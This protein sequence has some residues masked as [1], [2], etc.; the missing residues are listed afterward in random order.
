MPTPR[1]KPLHRRALTVERLE[2]RRLL[3]ADF[4]DAPIST[5]VSHEAIGPRL[6]GL[7]DVDAS[8]MSTVGAVGDGSDDDGVFYGVLR[9]GQTGAVITVNVQNAPTGA[10][11]DAWW[12]FNGNNAWTADE[13]I[14]DNLPVVEG[15]NA[16]TFDIPATA[17][18]GL[19]YARFRLSTAGDLNVSGV[20]LDGEVEDYYIPIARGDDELFSGLN[21]ISL[22]T[23]YRVIQADLDG[24]GDDDLITGGGSRVDWHENL[25]GAFATPRQIGVTSGN[26]SFLK[27]GDIDGDGD[28]DVFAATSSYNL[29]WFEND[30][31][32]TFT[33]QAISPTGGVVDLGDLDGDGDWDLITSVGSAAVYLN[34]GVTFAFSSSLATDMSAVASIVATDLDGDADVDVLAADTDDGAIVWF[35]NNGSG[36]LTRHTVTTLADL[37]RSAMPA[38]VDGDGDFDVVASVDADLVWY[39]NDG[40]GEFTRRL[41][42]EFAGAGLA[43]LGASDIDGDGDVDLLGATLNHKL[44]LDNDGSESFVT[45]RLYSAA[46]SGNVIVVDVDGD[47]RL[48]IVSARGSS[49]PLLSWQRQ[50]AAMDFGDAPM[51]YRTH[52]QHNGARHNAVGPRLGALRDAE[53]DGVHDDSEA[54]DDGVTFGTLQVGGVGTVTVNVQDAPDGARLDAWIDFDGDGSWGLEGERIAANLAVVEGDNEL[55]FAVPSWAAAGVT[56]ARFRLS[57]EGGHGVGGAA[58]DGEVEDYQV[59]LTAPAPATGMFG[60]PTTI[61]AASGLGFI[62]TADVDRDGDIDV[63]TRG[64]AW[65]EN[66]GSEGFVSHGVPGGA[67]FGEDIAA[68]D[69]DSDGDVDFVGLGNGELVWMENDGAQNFTLRRTPLLA[70][71]NSLVSLAIADMDGDGD[72]DVVATHLFS[73]PAIYLLVNDGS[74]QFATR[75]IGMLSRYAT[76]VVAADMDRDGDLDVVAGGQGLSSADVVWLQNDGALGF[77]Q[78]TV[79]PMA[80]FG[81]ANA[82]TEGVAVGDLDGD[83]DLDVVAAG[84]AVSVGSQVRASLS[85]HEQVDGGAFVQHDLEFTRNLRWATLA[86]IDGDGDLDILTSG[87][88]NAIDLYENL[89][90]STFVRRLVSTSLDTGWSVAAA[91]MDGDGD[92][93]VVGVNVATGVG[94]AWF[95]NLGYDEPDYGDAPASYGTLRANGGAEHNSAGPRLGDLRD[96]ETDGVPNTAADG[97]G[98]DDD[99]VTFG[100]LRAGEAGATITINVQNAAAGARVDAWIDFNGDGLWAGADEHVVDSASVVDGDNSFTFSVSPSAA[101]GTTYARVRVSTAGHQGP[102]GFAADGEVEDYAVTV[103]SPGETTGEYAAFRS[104]FDSITWVIRTADIDGDGD[105]DIVSDSTTGGIVWHENLN[106]GAFLRHPLPGAFSGSTDLQVVD[107]DRDGDA[108]FVTIAG[109]NVSW[110]E[111]NGDQSFRRRTIFTVAGTIGSSV[112]V[113]DAD[114]DGDWDVLVGLPGGIRWFINNGQ[115]SFASVAIAPSTTSRR[116]RAVDLDGDGDLD[117]V[118]ATPN[119][120][121]LENRGGNYTSHAQAL[122]FVDDFVVADVDR[123]GDLDVVT[124]GS[125]VAWHEN[126][127]GATFVP[128]MIPVSVTSLSTTVQG[129]LSVVDA[130]GD[131]DLDILLPGIGQPRWFRNDGAQNFSLVTVG[132]SLGPPEAPATNSIS[133]VAAD[134]NGDGRLEVLIGSTNPAQSGW[135]EPL[136]PGDYDRNGRVDE[137]DRELWEQTLGQPAT[138]PGS[139][140]DGDA[141]GQV[142]E[143]D[144]AVWEQHAGQ[145]LIPRVQ[146][147]HADSGLNEMIDGNDFLVWQ[148]RVGLLGLVAA[149]YDWDLSGGVDGG[150]LD[151]WRRQYGQGVAPDIAWIFSSPGSAAAAAALNESAAESAAESSLV[152]SAASSELPASG[153]EAGIAIPANVSISLDATPSRHSRPAHAPR[154]RGNFAA[155]VDAA[156]AAPGSNHLPPARRAWDG[157]SSPTDG[158]PQKDLAVTLADEAFGQL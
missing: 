83:G 113:V 8:A 59:T 69:L 15:D 129:Q 18:D 86:D 43:H 138:P 127:G 44:W 73:N 16:V 128:H 37:I 81:P 151:V 144:L 157:L 2:S 13:Q 158:K 28:I 14:A 126:T 79:K 23:T 117:I 108:D 21:V 54:E 130:D 49:F 118:A 137:A 75:Q 76:S 134:L 57:S 58:L 99:G 102:T 20:G 111:N 35:E 145:T 149:P 51:P 107:F 120:V 125:T 5:G 154:G 17:S 150:D 101:L 41:V 89:G 71:L 78:R 139:G 146:A 42:A 53:A 4:G 148:R 6:G 110:Y 156:L 98:A 22:V 38:D 10:R 62:T 133:I 47:G 147:A 103:E 34:N 67:S 142:D 88:S 50:L 63:I 36:G 39:E 48:D 3:A 112:D 135:Y 90:N 124:R 26:V 52:V 94:V 33:A 153:A 100:L 105:I 19:A 104:A 136:P 31:R 55:T 68:G 95:A 46:P 91:D 93:D 77:L 121:W 114:G 155:A 131:G 141:D 116:A 32:L 84:Q 60:G 87:H 12:D 40:D 74:E 56:F 66:R 152:A 9:V 123:D 27:A 30:G 65:F 97:D 72:N 106:D 109:S 61:A 140:A 64:L 11:L 25:G 96:A 70:G 119:L 82:P 24:D 45:H 1:R 132:P 7:R 122:G 115:Q 85:W 143:D 92:L 80:T 29:R